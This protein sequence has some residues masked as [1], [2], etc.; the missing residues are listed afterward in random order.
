MS[1]ITDIVAM[2]INMG[3]HQPAN[4]WRQFKAPLQAPC[5]SARQGVN[6]M[7]D[8]NLSARQAALAFV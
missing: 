2:A 3:G 1:A 6:A 4:R 5:G 8:P 7:E